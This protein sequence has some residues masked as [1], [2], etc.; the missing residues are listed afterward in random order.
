VEGF[1]MLMTIFVIL[2]VL[3][4]LGVQYLHAMVRIVIVP[5]SFGA[6]AC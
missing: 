3:W 4:L 2:M 6:R 5:Y 1:A